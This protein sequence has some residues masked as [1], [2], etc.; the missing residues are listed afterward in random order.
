MSDYWFRV[1]KTFEEFTKEGKCCSG[2]LIEVLF[3]GRHKLYLVG[4]INNQGCIASG[5]KP[6]P[7]D[8]IITRYKIIWSR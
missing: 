3:N 6:F 8:A 4:D 7:D 5:G 2:I 1:D